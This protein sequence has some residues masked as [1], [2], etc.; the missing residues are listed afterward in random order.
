MNALARIQDIDPFSIELASSQKIYPW[1]TE[2][3]GLGERLIT[4][5]DRRYEEVLPRTISRKL[6]A[7]LRK[8]QPQVIAIPGYHQAP[9][10]AAAKWTHTNRG[11]VILMS[12]TTAWDHPRRWWRELAK[13]WWLRSR[14]DAA[15][16]GGMPHRDYFVQLG[17]DVRRI[18]DRYDVVDNDYFMEHCEALRKSPI[19]RVENGLP[20]RYFLYVGRFAPEKN[21]RNLLRAYRHYRQIEPDGWDLVIVGDGPQRQ[22]LHRIVHSGGIPGVHWPGFK[23]VEDLP[24]YYAFAGCFIL[25][26]IKEPWGLVVNEAM[27]AG[28]PILASKRCGCAADLVRNGSNGFTFNP[29]DAQELTGLMQRMA[30]LSDH[31]RVAMGTASRE[32]ISDWTPEV[33]AEQLC[34]AV[35]AAV[36]I[37]P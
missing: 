14:V 9:L 27:A 28:L 37:A 1:I 21:L 35:R 36:A 3:N 2:R 5:F 13:R 8:L 16:V 10:R 23:Q 19:H 25:P 24:L 11:G 32:I 15:F 30:A 7:V 4:L 31:E 6:V 22:E 26:S 20:E 34:R 33:W 12:E 17:V 18:W 29:A